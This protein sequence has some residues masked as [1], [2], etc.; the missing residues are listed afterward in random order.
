MVSL[1]IGY[2][3][4]GGGGCL[5]GSVGSVSAFVSRHGPSILGSSSALGSLLSGD[6]L[7]PQP[8]TPPVLSLSLSLSHPSQNK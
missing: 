3:Q 4:A 5:G 7:L 6:V 8:L 2:M 1:L